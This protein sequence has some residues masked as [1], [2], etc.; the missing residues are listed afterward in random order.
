LQVNGKYTASD[1]KM[2]G[3]LS[4]VWSIKR[5]FQSFQIDHIRRNSNKEADKV[6]NE[7]IDKHCAYISRREVLQSGN[8]QYKTRFCRYWS[9][10][11]CYHEPDSVNCPFANGEEDLMGSDSPRDY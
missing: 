8:P 9:R 4:Q 7:A 1:S 2:K 10:G 3:Y 5:D 11:Y 6:A